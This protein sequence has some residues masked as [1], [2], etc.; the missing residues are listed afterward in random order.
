MDTI[1]A[2]TS[3]EEVPS[4]ALRD[5]LKS[6]LLNPWN[7]NFSGLLLVLCALALLSPLVFAVLAACF[8]ATDFLATILVD[9][10]RRRQFLSSG[11]LS[12]CAV[13]GLAV[14]WDP[15][16]SFFFINTTPNSAGYWA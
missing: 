2:S 1:S 9:K 8:V 3:N 12:S 16:F 13:V 10:E 14:G 11:P 15:F 4:P 5:H 6:T 7:Y